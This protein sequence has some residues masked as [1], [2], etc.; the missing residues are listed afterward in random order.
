MACRNAAIKVIFGR[1][2]SLAELFGGDGRVVAIRRS[3][4]GCDTCTLHM[5]L[6][7][8]VPVD[9]LARP[10]RTPKKPMK[11]NTAPRA[12]E[13]SQADQKWPRAGV[14]KSRDKHVDQGHQG[15]NAEPGNPN[16]I[17]VFLR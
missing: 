3:C 7:L 17:I 2:V 13:N 8:P 14:G 15:H 4:F 5:L 9:R 10:D 11:M 12:D 6:R 16:C 1:S